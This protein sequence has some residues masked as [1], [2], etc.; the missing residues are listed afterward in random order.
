MSD[1]VVG[2]LSRS[3]ASDGVYAAWIGLND[4]GIAEA[5]AREPFDALVL[6]MQH[7]GVDFVGASRGIQYAALAGKPTI[8]RINVADFACA[9]RLADAGAAGVIAPMINNGDDARRFAE[10]M[11]FPPNGRRSWGPRACL[12]L[13]GLM[14]VEYLHGADAI[15]MAIAMVETREALDALDDILG[16]PGID[17]VFIGPSDLSIAL[18]DGATV[19]PRGVLVDAAMTKVAVAA[20]KH[21]KFAG[22]FTFD[23][24]SAKAA[25]SRGFAMCSIA[26]DVLLLRAAAKREL[27][28]AR[29]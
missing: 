26:T 27:D 14:G 23:G 21:G 2:K 15:T 24:Q 13:S 3:L 5:L 1:A 7:G 25:R 10:F 16:V 19:D 18:S 11:K 6:D 9:S 28:A 4:P 12:P 29:G 22:L 20:K 8:V 17:G